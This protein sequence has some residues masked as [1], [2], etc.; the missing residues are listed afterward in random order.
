VAKVSS[1]VAVAVTGI[2]TLNF[3]Q[4][5]QLLI[6]F[7][8]HQKDPSLGFS[9]NFAHQCH[10]KQV[11]LIFGMI[12]IFPQDSLMAFRRGSFL[13]YGLVLL[14]KNERDRHIIDLACLPCFG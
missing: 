5:K 6:E 14:I 8:K 3:R 10:K 13:E 12:L 2:I 11:K 4:C 9:N 7:F 1:Y